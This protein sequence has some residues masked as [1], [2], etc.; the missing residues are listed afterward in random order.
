MGYLEADEHTVQAVQRIASGTVNGLREQSSRQ[1]RGVAE[2]TEAPDVGAP[3]VQAG[4]AGNARGCSKC[5]RP[6]RRTG[7]SAP[8]QMYPNTGGKTITT[9][10]AQT[11]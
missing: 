9:I 6:V 3:D 1:A 11:A 5:S 8:S 4:A 2:V 10:A 7:L